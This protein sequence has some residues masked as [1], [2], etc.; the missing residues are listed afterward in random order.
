MINKLFKFYDGIN[1]SD[2]YNCVIIL[3]LQVM[4]AQQDLNLIKTIIPYQLS[5][6][7]KIVQLI[8]PIVFNGTWIMLYMT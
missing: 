5:N 4:I 2:Q 6:L 1:Y 7:I 3:D 8:N